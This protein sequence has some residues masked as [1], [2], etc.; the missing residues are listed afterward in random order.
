MSEKQPIIIKK[1]K[2]AGHG[3]HGGAWK[4]A[5]ADFVTAMMAF[6]LLL[7]LLTATPVENLQGLADYFSP[8]IGLQGKM[9]IGFSGGTGTDPQ[10]VSSGDWA[11]LGLIFG[12][13]PSGPIVKF[14]EQSNYIDQMHERVNIKITESEVVEVI[15]K[16]FKEFSKY[17]ENILIDYKPEGLKIK[18]I[19]KEKRK[20]FKKGTAKLTSHTKLLLKKIASIV[21]DI[22]NYIKITCFSSDLGGSKANFTDWELAM[23]RANVTR[24]YLISSGVDKQQVYKMVAIAKENNK[25]NRQNANNSE[26]EITLL[27]DIPNDEKSE[28]NSIRKILSN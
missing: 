21:K 14:P 16:S 13:A 22:P 19:D 20:M 15:K 10:G 11:S 4:V 3:H 23:E 25:L 5:Y 26:I 12:A 27:R 18:I 17:K 1:I 6:F 7:W 9:G 24:K 8:T 2:K 28:N